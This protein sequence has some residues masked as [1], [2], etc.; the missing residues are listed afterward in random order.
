MHEAPE[1]F[2]TPSMKYPK[3]PRMI[4]LGSIGQPNLGYLTVAESS[5]NIPFDLKRIYWTYYTPHEVVRGHHAHRELEQVIIAVSGSLAITTEGPGGVKNE[6]NLLSPNQ[7]LYVPEM[8]WREIKFS[9]NAVLLSLASAL[10]SEEDYIRSYD[11][12]KILTASN[13]AR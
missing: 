4:D 11:Q 9:H 3:V 8:H 10:Y 12:F 7:G 13:K 5:N 2:K 1:V 6:F